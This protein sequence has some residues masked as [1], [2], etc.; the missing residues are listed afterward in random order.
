[1]Q[2]RRSQGHND[3]KAKADYEKFH[4]RLIEKVVESLQDIFGER[5]E[6]ADKVIERHMRG[7][8]KWGARD[9]RFFAESVYDCVRWWRKLWFAL[10]EEPVLETPQLMR[11]W[12]ISYQ[13]T[14]KYIPEWR[15]FEDLPSS[16][17]IHRRLEKASRAVLRSIPDWMDELCAK[18]LG[19][20][21][22][23]IL[24]SL[25]QKAPVDLRTNNLRISRADLQVKLAEEG[26]VT[27]LISDSDVG[28]TLVERKN[29]FATKCFH[30]GYFEVQDR[31]SQKIAKLLNPQPG[32]RVVDACAG[33][34]GKTL[35]LAALMKNKGRIIAMDIHDWK[36][37]EL[38]ARVKRNQVSCVETRLI[39]TTKVVKRQ[40]ETA[41]RLLLDVPC[42]GLGVLR[43]NPDSKWKLS[44]TE[45]LA[46]TTKQADILRLYS[47]MVKPG[48]SMV[49][50]T[51]S[52]LP[53]ENERQLEKFLAEN[54]GWTLVETLRN[55]PDLGQGDGF[56]AGLLR[57]NKVS[58]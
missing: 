33:A 18:E 2:N 4:R 10:G 15:D 47:R 25:N 30:E 27:E 21:W 36:L 43:R 14:D 42:S 39:D 5:H 29:V 58:I 38:K 32:E 52:F 3:G 31:A 11:L 44:P 54:S 45:I 8:R 17:Q 6:F 53:S 34:G 22:E 20:R 49:Y 40:E 57:R 7:Q 12:A 24:K 9:R 55:D 13:L 51:C 48:G 37:Q 23:S 41:D 50:A 26:I 46:L 28:L 19:D 35:H 56:F 16:A 1:M